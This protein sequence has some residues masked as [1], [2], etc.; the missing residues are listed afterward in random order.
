MTPARG[1]PGANTAEGDDALFSLT[2]ISGDGVNNTAMVWQSLYSNTNGNSNT[3]VGA[4]TLIQHKRRRKH[5][6][7]I[8]TLYLNTSG[9][10]NTGTGDSALANNPTGN[11]NIALGSATLSNNIYG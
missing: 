5:S 9:R 6:H 8:R 1:Y 10:G 11:F 3:A 7:R 4:F 2:T